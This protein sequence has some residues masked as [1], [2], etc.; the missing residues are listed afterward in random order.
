VAGLRQI[1]SPPAFAPSQYGLLS[2]VQ[3]AAPGDN[4]WMNGVTYETYCVTG[5]GGTTFEECIVVTGSGGPP[6]APPSKVTNVQNQ[7]RGATPFTV[8]TEF[9][10]SPVGE[11]VADAAA[12]ALT[13]AEPWQVERAFWTGQAS[14]LNYKTVFPHLAENTAAVDGQGIVL[15]TPATSVTGSP[16][17]LSV[18][19]GLLEDALA[20]C[21][22][23]EGVLHVPRRAIAPISAATMASSQG[24]RLRTLA[25][26]WIAAGA[27]YPGT[28]PD[29]SAAPAGTTWIYATSAIMAFRGPVRLLDSPRETL[30]RAENTQKQIAERTVLLAWECCHFAVQVTL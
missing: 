8:Y 28:A 6:P 26:N 16:V 11:E 22:G 12:A 24:P 14:A 2:V 19:L 5:M 18:G 10:C 3:D 15:Q 30:D 9:D 17:P 7:F 21:Y 23:G 4:R 25:G 20:D 13:R 27:G 29:G 1:V